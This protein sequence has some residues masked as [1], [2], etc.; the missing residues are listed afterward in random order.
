MSQAPAIKAQAQ[1][2][3]PPRE[4][5]DGPTLRIPAKAATHAGFR[6]WVTSEDFNERGRF[7]Y[8]NGEIHIDMSPES[9]ESHVKVKGTV[10]HGLMKLN[11][12]HDLGELYT[13]GILVTNTEAGVSNEP[14]VTFVSW[15][16]F[17]NGRV[18]IVP[19]KDL[20]SDYL[21]IVGAPDVVVEVI[22]PSSISKDTKLLR[23][24]YHR[25]GIPEY[26]LIDARQS[27][28]IQFEILRHTAEGYVSVEPVEG[29]IRSE[30]FGRRF[31]LER[32]RNRV[33]RW[34]YTLQ[35]APA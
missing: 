18:S 2:V 11:E 8:L 31:R 27:D 3:E 4:E 22:S 16:T 6:D 20:P 34:K 28:E 1:T 7:A 19:R 10:Y 13:D 21:E 23:A 25:A 26:W 5:Y 9:A 35:N 12:E 17:E 29:W 32:T 33:G 30:V 24:A 15:Q 14:D